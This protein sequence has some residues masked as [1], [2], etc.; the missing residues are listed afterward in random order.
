MD[1][2]HLP[3]LFAGI[4]TLLII[5]SV[6]IGAHHWKSEKGSMTQEQRIELREER[7]RSFAE[8]L[9]LTE[10]ELRKQLSEGKSM[11][12]IAKERGITLELPPRWVNDE[13][14][15]AFLERMAERMNMTPGELR[16]EF[17]S[18]KRLLDIAEERGIKLSFPNRSNRPSS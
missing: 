13:G 10:E 18:G 12:E 1:A 2:I 7:F 5:I 14:R 15:T 11:M 9:A 3:S 16:D 4:S 17:A 8:Q 6:L